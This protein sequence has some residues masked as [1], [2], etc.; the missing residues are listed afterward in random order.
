MV[1]SA[2]VGFFIVATVGGVGFGVAAADSADDLA[3]AGAFGFD[4]ATTA[5]TVSKGGGAAV[6]NTPVESESFAEHSTLAAASTRTID[7]GLQ[8]IDERERAERERIAA[9]NIAI[10]DRVAAG[11]AKQ[12]FDSDPT[13]QSVEYGLPGVDWTI[14]HDAFIE[15]WTGRIDAYLDG[16]PLAGYGAVFAEAA[17]DNGV[18]PRWSPSISNTE[19][20]KGKVC[21]LPCNAWGWGASVWPDWDTAIRAHVAGL[22]A[23]YGYSI[24]PEAAQIYCP[25][26]HVN[27]YHDTFGQMG[28]I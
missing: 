10:F 2:I 11:K 9:D 24:T 22:A 27:W 16:S 5:A 20:G 4:E 1:F 6:A 18:D 28:T 23:G 21:F 26:N 3:R 8:M 19:S 14:G 25:P 7:S 13:G 17:W 12:G 15:E